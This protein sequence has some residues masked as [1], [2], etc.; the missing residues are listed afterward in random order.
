IDLA[1]NGACHGLI[2]GTT[3]S[4][5]TVTEQLVA[6]ALANGNDPSAL[7]L[8]LID[9]K[10]GV[11]WRGFEREAHL[12]H[13]V[14][15]DTAEAVA[16][17]GWAL[18]ELDRRKQNGQQGPRIFVVVDEVRELIAL[19]GAA[20][21][22]AICRLTSL[23]REL[24]LHLLLATQ[25]PVAEAL[26]GA[27]AKANLPLRLVGRMLNA[28]DAYV[29]SGV[30]DS[31]AETL[32]GNGDFLAAAGGALVRVQVGMATHRELYQLPRVE[33]EPSRLDLAAHNLDRALTATADLQPEHLAL[34]LAT[35]R[36]SRWLSAELRI[37]GDRAGRLR[38]FAVAV[39][40]RLEELGFEIALR[41]GEGDWT[42]IALLGRS[43]CSGAE[44]NREE[45]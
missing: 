38:R 37:G 24:G 35:N 10:G 36:G 41:T 3:G 16:A 27:V 7:R 32:T 39:L 14:I 25:Y 2:A 1:G 23:G 18:A 45:E 4:G 11:H 22:E 40:K 20:V 43:E 33:G 13:P 28:S 44:C 26:G 42:K 15:A 6:W 8:I 9:G 30:K 12:C 5:K 34:A 29:A 31:G 21:A 19:G 17:L